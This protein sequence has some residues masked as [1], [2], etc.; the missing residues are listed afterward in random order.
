MNE[1]VKGFSDYKALL[2]RHKLSN[3]LF[4]FVCVYA[5]RLR[6]WVFSASGR[7]RRSRGAGR[8]S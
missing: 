7:V 6:C 8:P 5:R 3:H 2:L 1:G 4:V